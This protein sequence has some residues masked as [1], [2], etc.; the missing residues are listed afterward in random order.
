M[1]PKNI[2]TKG[3]KGKIRINLTGVYQKPKSSFTI[4][5]QSQTGFD[6]QAEVEPVIAKTIKMMIS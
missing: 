4:P 3:Y 5:S 6:S 2:K 1:Y